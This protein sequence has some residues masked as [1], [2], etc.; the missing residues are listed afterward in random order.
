[1]NYH[2]PT[3]DI[4]LTSI[5]RVDVCRK[6]F[7]CFVRKWRILINLSFAMMNARPLLSLLRS[8]AK[9]K[10]SIIVIKNCQ[11][12]ET[13]FRRVVQL[14]KQDVMIFIP[15]IVQKEMK[16]RAPPLRLQAIL[17]NAD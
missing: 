11:I 14:S 17:K 16:S 13:I 8:Q 15:E 3:S 5:S 10:R 7:E 1:M 9:A 6:K 2:R 12:V 4:D